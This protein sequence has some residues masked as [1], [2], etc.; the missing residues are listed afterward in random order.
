MHIHM[1]IH[2]YIHTNIHICTHVHPHPPI[3][4][5][6]STICDSL[7]LSLSLCVCLC[8]S[9]LSLLLRLSLPLSLSVSVFISPSPQFHS[10]CF[11]AVSLCLSV[12]IS[13]S[14]ILPRALTPFLFRSL[15]RSILHIHTQA[16]NHF[17]ALIRFLSLSPSLLLALFS[18]PCSL[19]HTPTKTHAHMRARISQPHI[20]APSREKPSSVRRLDTLFEAPPASANANALLN[21]GAE[22]GI[23]MV[24]QQSSIDEANEVASEDHELNEPT[25]NEVVD[26]C[27]F[28]GISTGKTPAKTRFV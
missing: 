20:F 22:G 17:L 16:Q 19:T 8:L 28:A 10:R 27:A 4:A 23:S 14:H 21:W 2:I 15:F 26:F 3:H 18:Y 11:L 7:S 9:S 6:S 13:L 1:H 5:H 12:F 24:L 25:R